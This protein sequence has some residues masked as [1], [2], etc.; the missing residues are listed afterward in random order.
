MF[1]LLDT[2]TTCYNM[3]KWEANNTSTRGIQGSHKFER[4]HVFK[5][6]LVSMILEDKRV[7]YEVL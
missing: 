2:R 5:L 7:P 3:G 4:L 1:L 6:H